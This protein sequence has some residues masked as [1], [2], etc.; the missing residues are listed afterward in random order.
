MAIVVIHFVELDAEAA[1]AIAR[2]SSMNDARN[3][4]EPIDPAIAARRP[5]RDDDVFTRQNAL[6]RPNEHP[7]L[8]EIQGEIRDDAKVVLSHHLT[9]DANVPPKRAPRR[10]PFHLVTLN[11]PAGGGP[12]S[13]I[14][15]R[16]LRRCT[17][18]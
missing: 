6:A 12:I 14:T 11:A 4:P 10:M 15:R 17:A 7:A 9:V 1:P 3:V 16:T 2:P 13:G 18:P 8:R 5:K